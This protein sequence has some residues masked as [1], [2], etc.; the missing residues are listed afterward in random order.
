MSQ[1]ISVELAQ[2]TSLC[3]GYVLCEEALSTTFTTIQGAFEMDAFTIFDQVFCNAIDS[4]CQD[5]WL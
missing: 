5:N 1:T 3:Q 2:S 4:T